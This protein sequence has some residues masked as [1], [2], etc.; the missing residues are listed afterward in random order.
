MLALAVF[1]A[2]SLPQVSSLDEA[3]LAPQFL[4]VGGRRAKQDFD[5]AA[6]CPRVSVDEARDH[7]L[8]EAHALWA[9]AL[10]PHLEGRAQ[11]ILSGAV[12]PALRC[13]PPGQSEPFPLGPFIT[14]AIKKVNEIGTVFVSF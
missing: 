9:V 4:V 13:A 6:P 7:F 12:R 2:V 10:R 3:D 8:D 1:G 5:D 11:R 14:E